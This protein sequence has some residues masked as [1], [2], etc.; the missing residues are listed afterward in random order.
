MDTNLEVKVIKNDSFF[1]EVESRIADGNRVRIRAKGNS[2][3]P[4]IRD[5]KDEVILEKTNEKSFQKGRLLLV[6]TSNETYILHRVTRIS[7]DNIVLKGDGNLSLF[8]YC[9]RAEVIAEST[10]VIRN[11]KLIKV[12][13][14][15]W[16]LYRYFWPQ[17][18]YLR[19]IG[20]ALY[21]RNPFLKEL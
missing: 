3:L 11:T 20:L 5:G 21:R 12:G 15:K 1:R 2:M 9:S 13:S 19:R 6:R 8:E 16:N 17:N 10:E 14:F 7:K 4:F 18:Y